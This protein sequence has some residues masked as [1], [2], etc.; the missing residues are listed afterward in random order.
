MTQ[1]RLVVAATKMDTAVKTQVSQALAIQGYCRSVIEQESIDLSGFPK[2]AKIGGE[3]NSGLTTAKAHA[4]LYLD[5][6][7]P[8]ILANVANIANYYNLHQAVATSMPPG[9]SE[10]EWVA[11]LSALKDQAIDFKGKAGTV[12]TSLGTLR[13][14]LARDVAAFAQ[15]VRDLN[16]A[17]GGDN[18][19]LADINKQLDDLEKKI[20][21]AAVGITISGL[22]ILGGTFLIL[23]GAIATLATAG[24]S[25]VLIIGGAAFVAVGVAGTV[26]LSVAMA[27][28]L[29]RKGDLIEQRENLKAE[30]KLATGIASGYEGLRLKA[31][32]AVTAAIDMKNAWDFL[33]ADLGNLATDLEKGVLNAEGT[34]T[35]FLTAANS[36]IQTIRRDMET[37]RA[38]MAGVQ[39]VNAPAGTKVG[40]LTHSTSQKL[41]A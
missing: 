3:I 7:Q 14:N 9:T 12:V 2:L 26:V 20:A 41:A 30:V 38:Q 40:N 31:E 1:N 33:S 27:K 35:L 36:E 25:T 28:L 39:Q 37:I 21:A 6:I 10:K 4:R 24:L 5:S 29:D 18:G 16:A 17:V 11:Q 34:R 32:A 23:V 22:A 15:V 13:D 8:T 19:V